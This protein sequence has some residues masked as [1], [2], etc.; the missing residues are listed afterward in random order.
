MS[1]CKLISE[2]LAWPV[3]GPGEAAWDHWV[4]RARGAVHNGSTCQPLINFVRNEQGDGVSL[5]QWEAFL[6]QSKEI[7]SSKG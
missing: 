7:L 2:A 4:M 1:H 5:N 6:A 3:Q